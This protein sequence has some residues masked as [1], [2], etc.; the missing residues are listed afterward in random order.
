MRLLTPHDEPKVTQFDATEARLGAKTEPLS[1][2]AGDW[3]V[4]KIPPGSLDPSSR[5]TGLLASTT[6]GI[7]SFVTQTGDARVDAVKCLT[8]KP[9]DSSSRHDAALA[10]RQYVR[11]D[12]SRIGQDEILGIAIAKTDFK[13]LTFEIDPNFKSPPAPRRSQASPSRARAELPV[14][15]TSPLSSARSGPMR[16]AVIDEHK[17]SLPLNAPPHRMMKMPISNTG[18][19]FATQN[20]S[21]K[22]NHVLV[23]K[24]PGNATLARRVMASAASGTFSMNV[25]LFQQGMADASAVRQ[26]RREKP[27]NTGEVRQRVD[28]QP[29]DNL[30]AAYVVVRAQTDISHLKLRVEP[31]PLRARDIGFS[32]A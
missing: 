2:K 28:V 1:G 6:E 30:D 12:P 16:E 32:A 7:F 10:H 18:E 20:A 11:L 17:V 31:I 27:L 29:I 19:A 26:A 13:N 5:R 24:L 23:F 21:A 9:L 8:G 22:A 15:P 25:Q 14:K 4:V 3:V